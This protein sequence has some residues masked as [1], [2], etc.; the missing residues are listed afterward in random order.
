MRLSSR[1]LHSGSGIGHAPVEVAGDRPR[2][3]VADEVLAEL[4]DV[5]P[6]ALAGL[7]PAAERLGEG[8]QLEEEL[9]RLD[10]L[11]RLAVDLRPRVLEVLRVE[12]VAAVV[13]LVA[14]RP[15][16]A[17]DRA[18]ALDVAVRQPAPGRRVDRGQLER[19]TT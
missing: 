13:A 7:Q 17:A 6:P 1:P 4:Q 19:S 2:L 5:R 18:G 11:R 14:A 15:V 8:R 3:E 10:E 9:R 16:V 12:L